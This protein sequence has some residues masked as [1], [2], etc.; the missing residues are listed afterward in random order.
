MAKIDSNATPWSF[1][2][3]SKQLWIAH[4]QTQRPLPSFPQLLHVAAER[5][6]GPEYHHEG[7][8]RRN[9]THCIYKYTLAG[10]GCFRD[11]AGEHRVPVG[12]GFL[13][14]ICNPQTAYYYPP[15]GRGPWEFFYV[16]FI[17]ATAWVR[18][19]VARYGGVYALPREHAVLQRLLACRPRGR[20]TS[21]LTPA[22]GAELVT[23]LLLALAASR[24]V[25]PT[26]KAAG[27]LVRQARQL[28][29]DR[30]EEGLNATSLA[31]H[32]RVS[33][34]HLGRAFRE[35]TGFTP[36]RYIL[37][38]KMLLGCRLLKETTLSQ[39][40]ISA[41]LAF[42]SPAHFSRTFRRTMFMTPSRFRAVGS[43]PLA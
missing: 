27:T 11:E 22:A 33:R 9:E 43:V 10:E 42:P 12:H 2:M 13:V 20:E 6:T 29:Q 8:F 21:E 26:A 3:R 31:R 15:G 4:F 32:L 23:G 30:I 25:H 37:R 16:S 5:Q 14:E 19:L 36:Y 40:E 41:R 28:V 1:E 38:Q 39:K 24:E 18:D 35:E 17:G 7:R 34:E